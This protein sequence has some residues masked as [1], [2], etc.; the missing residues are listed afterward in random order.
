MILQLKR[1][2]FRAQKISARVS[3]PEYLSLDEFGVNPG[4]QNQKYELSGIVVHL[5][6]SLYSGHY[7]SYVKS[8]GRWF[9][10]VS[11]DEVQR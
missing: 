2:D 1:F 5:G 6:G 7:V 9:S 10:V 8:M 4:T 11:S 3:F